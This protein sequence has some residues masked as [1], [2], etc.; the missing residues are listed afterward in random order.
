M[1]DPKRDPVAWAMLIDE[2][3]DA[4]KR[5]GNLVLDMT[6]DES[7]FRVELARVYGHLNRVWNLRDKTDAW[8][9]PSN[10]DWD[11][12]YEAARAFPTDLEP[13]A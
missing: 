9:D 11:T 12:E 8:H 10:P 3:E 2:L 4:Q 13:I 7:D 6:A 5:L 1:I